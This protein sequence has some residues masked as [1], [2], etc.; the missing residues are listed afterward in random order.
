M[1]LGQ[2]PA[3]HLYRKTSYGPCDEARAIMLA[4]Q[5]AQ[6]SCELSP[7]A[8]GTKLLGLVYGD[9]RG[10]VYFSYDL[11]NGFPGGYYDIA[12]AFNNGQTAP[13]F[14][15]I[16]SSSQSAVYAWADCWNV[17]AG[18][19]ALAYTGTAQTARQFTDSDTGAIQHGGDQAPARKYILDYTVKDRSTGNTPGVMLW[20]Y[21]RVLSYDESSWAAGTHTMTNTLTA[22]RW[23]TSGFGSLRTTLT[24]SLTGG[25]GTDT[26]VTALSYTK[27]D[28]TSGQ[29][30]PTTFAM[31][32]KNNSS[33]P[34]SSGIPADVLL[35]E[36][37]GDQHALGAFLPL[38][39]GDQGM[40][41]IE[42]YTIDVTN[43]GTLC[44]AMVKPLLM[45]VV[46]DAGEANTVDC[47]R[48]RF[49]PT[50]IPDGACLSFLLFQNEIGI[51]DG[52]IN[53]VWN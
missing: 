14:F 4:A 2:A 50:L 16:L 41:S 10:N 21:D 31:K 36:N 47:W 42:S 8:L 40:N 29:A 46:P 43:T 52:N 12:K 6:F 9:R 11:A 18:S 45:M 51:V 49:A 15:M 48:D 3:L 28:G 1:A 35:F 53:F 39:P 19:A 37:S 44:F 27:Q 33:S 23:T 30:M 24:C 17:L 34:L 25:D 20:L 38:A 7:V 26:H 22:Q 5:G 32:L 13:G